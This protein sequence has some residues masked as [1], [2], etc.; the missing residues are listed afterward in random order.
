MSADDYDY[1]TDMRVRLS[2][3]RGELDGLS[4]HT[5]GITPP[6]EVAPS[7]E[8]VEGLNVTRLARALSL[9]GRVD[10][11]DASMAEWNAYA[12]DIACIYASTD[13]DDD[14]PDWLPR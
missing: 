10:I 12:V 5:P 11:D 3:P 14:A 9:I 8:V 2:D 13:V 7:Y 6:G 4:P 1:L